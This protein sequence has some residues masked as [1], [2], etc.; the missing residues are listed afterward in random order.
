MLQ[1]GSTFILMIAAVAAAFACVVTVIGAVQLTTNRK[2][3]YF[4]L[5]IPA[6]LITTGV[7]M[8]LSGRSMD[9]NGAQA[10][11]GALKSPLAIWVQRLCTIVIL[12]V[13]AERIISHFSQQ[14]SLLGAAPML[15]LG[16]IAFWVGSIASPMFFSAHPAIVRESFYTLPIGLA[17]LLLTADE[18]ESTLLSARDSIFIF[19]LVSY[20]VLPVLPQ[21]VLDTNYTQGLIPGLPRFA[22]LAPHAVILAML[23]QASLLC[24]WARP[25]ANRHLNT[26]AW[27]LG[28][29][30]LILAQSKTAWM[31]FAICALVMYLYRH[32]AALKQ[33]LADP[34]RP[35]LGILLAIGILIGITAVM[36]EVLF[37]NPDGRL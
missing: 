3:G 33:K 5:V 8:A 12:T 24:L 10:V 22:G 17:A 14:R 4:H 23:A 2:H 6:I 35:H 29:L 20:L 31:S 37:G 1:V 28:L 13:S 11:E 32:G 25:Y 16:F 7:A 34:E 30:T 26:A 18:G 27:I 21:V 15:T 19:Q 36:A 9:F